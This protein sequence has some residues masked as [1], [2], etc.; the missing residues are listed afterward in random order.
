[1][2][3]A[4]HAVDPLAEVYTADTARKILNMSQDTFYLEVRTGRLRAF[5]RGRFTMVRRSAIDQY[6]ALVEAESYDS[7]GRFKKDMGWRER[8]GGRRRWGHDRPL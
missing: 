2:L 4:R 1:M 8:G 7:E 3:L 6:L 5:K